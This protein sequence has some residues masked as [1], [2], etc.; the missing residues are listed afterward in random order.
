[1]EIARFRSE[2]EKSQITSTGSF[3]FGNSKLRTYPCLVKKQE[4]PPF[5]LERVEGAFPLVVYVC[6]PADDIIHYRSEN[7]DLLGFNHGFFL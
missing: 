3:P 1:M 5:P 4:N 7:L 2:K 6:C